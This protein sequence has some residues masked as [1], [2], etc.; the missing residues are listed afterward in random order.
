MKQSIVLALA[1]AVLG[2]SANDWDEYASLRARFLD[3]TKSETKVTNTQQSGSSKGGHA[4]GGKSGNAGSSRG[5]TGGHQMNRGS[6]GGKVG[7]QFTN[8]GGASM[9]QTTGTSNGGSFSGT[10]N[11][12]A[13]HMFGGG[14]FDGGS[15][16]GSYGAPS[17]GNIGTSNA[18]ITGSSNYVKPGNSNSANG[19]SQGKLMIPT[20]VP[21]ANIYRWSTEYLRQRLLI[22]R[23]SRWRKRRKWRT[24]RLG[25]WTFE[26]RQRGRR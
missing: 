20:I 19:G 7:S 14:M 17:I 26:R 15:T 13:P 18:G 24:N 4:K 21:V 3:S 12:A 5:S 25:R 6:N 9:G 1:A 8:Y 2:V 11:Q 16:G 22:I 23:S 10:I